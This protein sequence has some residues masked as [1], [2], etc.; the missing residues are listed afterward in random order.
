VVGLKS[1][2]PLLELKGAQVL[3]ERRETNEQLKYSLDC[4]RNYLVYRGV[5]RGVL[6]R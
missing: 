1:E 6:A 4:C 3:K 2:T 5:F